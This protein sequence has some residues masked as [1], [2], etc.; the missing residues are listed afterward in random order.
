M[1]GL[2]RSDAGSAFDLLQFRIRKRISGAR[3]RGVLRAELSNGVPRK[4]WRGTRLCVLIAAV[5]SHA[6]GS[7]I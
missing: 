1:Q 6:S 5:L 4:G 3:V 7:S 2:G